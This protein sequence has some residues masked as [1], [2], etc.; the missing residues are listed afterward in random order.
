[1]KSST[2]AHSARGEVAEGVGG[3][4]FVV[5]LVAAEAAAQRDGHGVL[6]QQIERPLDRPAGLDA[7]G[8][9]RV[10][11]GGHVHQ[12][13]RVG[14]DAGQPADRAGLVAAPAGA[15][16]Q[17]AD[18]LGAADLEHPIHGV[19]STPRSSVEVQTTQRSLPSRS[20]SSTHSR[21]PR[22]SE[23]WWSAMMPAQ[24]GRA[25]SSAWYQISA[26]ARVLVKTSA[27]SPSSMARDDLG[28]Q[29]Q[30]DL[31][32]PG[33]AL[34]RLGDERIDLERLG[35]EALHDAAGPRVPAG[36]ESEQ[37]V[38]RHVEVAERGGEAE[39]AERRPE[40]PEARQGELGLDA[41]LGGEQLV[42]LVHDDQLEM[43]EQLGARRR[44]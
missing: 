7:A 32:G 1:M 27:L 35:H 16:D 33:E 9:E 23:P 37:R 36:I 34:H 10:A 29:P 2:Q 26:V 28:Q 25:A 4:H 15:L 18:R 42:P 17:A 41:A 12:L 30:A 14:R 19:K 5:E 6:R 24:S 43:V 3:A 38:A 20:P 8:L 39:R 21:V 40:A 44:A 31:P 22:S 13:E 11:G